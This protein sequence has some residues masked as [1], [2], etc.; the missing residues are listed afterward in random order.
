[1][2][3]PRIYLPIIAAGCIYRRTFEAVGRGVGFSRFLLLAVGIG[4][5]RPAGGPCPNRMQ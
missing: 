3:D 2:E 4:E 1:M 5:S